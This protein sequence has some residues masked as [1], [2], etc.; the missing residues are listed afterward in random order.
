LNT[1]L[2][3]D[4]PKLDD[5]L[6]KVQAELGS[7]VTIV[8]A[9]RT[10]RGGVGGFFAKEWFEVIVD[11]GAAPT[12]EGARHERAVAS[13]PA[14][15]SVDPFLA[16]AAAIDDVRETRT[17]SPSPDPV[18]A[19]ELALAT[20]QSGADRPGPTRAP[21][22]S[23]SAADSAPAPTAT[24]PAP[25]PAPATRRLRD[26]ALP[27]L[28]EHLDAMIPAVLLPRGSSPT[29]AVVGDHHSVRGVA[30]SLAVRLGLD[31]SDVIVAS[32]EPQEG[33]PSWLRLHT[34]ADV[35][36]R[37]PRWRRSNSPRVIAVELSPGREGHAW[38]ASML[39]AIGADQV[40]LVA[41]AWQL[42]DQLT[43]KAAVL[44]GIDG[45][46]L[47]EMDAAAEPELFLEI[48]M[49]VLGI[50]G[51]PATAELWAALLYERRTD[52]DHR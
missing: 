23:A 30:G 20:A 9:N 11:P 48:E 4:G 24:A 34:P 7:S 49:D 26:L 51:R 10:R 41:K 31:E 28:L 37:S 25:I 40:R 19:F 47:V 27:S 42:T 5:L 18:H 43:A 21:T 44:G 12:P 22:A 39:E 32:P 3:F 33:M 6:E 8:E 15:A 36:A 52:A 17:S 45:L 50:D 2:K 13:E 29:I 16:L 1:L 14:D 46:D 38:A 35:A